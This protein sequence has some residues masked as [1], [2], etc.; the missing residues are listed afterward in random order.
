MRPAFSTA[1]P[2]MKIA[3]TEITAS[4]PKPANTRTGSI[5][6]VTARTIK[7]QNRDQIGPQSPPEK[8]DESG[9]ERAEYEDLF[10][11]RHQHSF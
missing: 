6:L 4:F 7:A 1:R 5:T 8:E 10:H 11:F 9:H 2:I 3:A